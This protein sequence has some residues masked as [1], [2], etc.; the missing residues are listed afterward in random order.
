MWDIW[1]EVETRRTADTAIRTTTKRLRLQAVAGGACSKTPIEK[2]IPTMRVTNAGTRSMKRTSDAVVKF[3]SVVGAW[4]F[5]A[6]KSVTQHECSGSEAS[7]CAAAC[8]A[9]DATSQ[10]T[11]SK[12][13]STAKP[14]ARG[15]PDR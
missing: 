9:G 13:S 10:S 5:P 14:I 4:K 3:A 7:G 6:S 1:L 15:K 11:A 8:R 2:R 12:F